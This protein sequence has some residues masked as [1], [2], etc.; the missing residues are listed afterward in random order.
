MALDIRY[1][2]NTNTGGWTTWNMNNTAQWSMLKG[3]NGF[4]DEF[5]QAQAN[6]RANIVAGKG[7]TFAYTGAPGTSP[8]PIFRRIFAG[9]RRCNDAREPGNPANY[10]LGELQ[11]F[12]LVQ[13]PGDVPEQRS[14]QLGPDDD[15]RHGHE[16]AAERH[17]HGD[18]PR[19]QPHRR[20]PAGQLL[21]GEPERDAGRTPTSR[22]TAG[23]T[24]YNAMQIEL[25]RR[26]SQGLLVA[27]QLPATRSAARP[28]SGTRCARTGTTSTAPAARITSFKAELG[29][30][31]AVRPGQEVG[32]RRRRSA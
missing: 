31:A 24:R 4:Y 5:R 14:D 8:L 18:R 30:R 16:R 6:L 23:N 1:V 29:V 20:R 22:R 13:Q 32:Q 27:G 2:G 12:V 10:T 15:R 9:H 26:M 19:R 7:N 3:E 25:R 21:H 17:R 11:E 28:G